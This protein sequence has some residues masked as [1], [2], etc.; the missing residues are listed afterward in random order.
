M[1][2]YLFCTNLTYRPRLEPK[3]AWRNNLYS[4]ADLTQ[5]STLA[6]AEPSLRILVHLM[7]DL[8][9]AMHLD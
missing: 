6:Q 9:Q 1:K 7:G 4:W 2:I 5:A 8:N 3:G